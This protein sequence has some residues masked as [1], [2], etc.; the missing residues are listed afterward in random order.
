MWDFARRLVI[1]AAIAIGLCSMITMGAVNYMKWADR[2]NCNNHPL[3]EFVELNYGDWECRVP[4]RDGSWINV[5][6]VELAN[7]K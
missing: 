3:A 6:R 2:E 1:T 7:P 4:L 5:E